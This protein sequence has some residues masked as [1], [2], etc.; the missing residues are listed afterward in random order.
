MQWKEEYALGIAEIDSQHQ[1]LF[2]LFGYI[3]DSISHKE[4]WSHTH[5]GLV[6]LREF[7]RIH[8]A[9]EEALMRLFGWEGAEDHEQDHLHFFVRLDE[10]ERRSLTENISSE[11]VTFLESWLTGHIMVTDKAYARH[12]L[13]GAP[14][15]ASF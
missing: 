11:M 9:V 5:F 15:V 10:I 7:A 6:Q 14:V 13:S 12:I 2:R 3:A 8:F 1:N 4:R